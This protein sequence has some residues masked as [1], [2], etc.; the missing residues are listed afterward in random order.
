MSFDGTEGTMITLTEGAALTA[1]YRSANP[2]GTKGHFF[3]KNKISALLVQ[4]G[5]KGLRIYY[6][7]DSATGKQELVVV[8]TDANGDDI[9][10][11]SGPLVLDRS[12]ACPPNCGTSN[13]L[14]S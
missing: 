12:V 4:T 14:N 9:L 13:S 8:A 11:S 7:I 10:A 1:A 6:G 3:G 2:S 5:T